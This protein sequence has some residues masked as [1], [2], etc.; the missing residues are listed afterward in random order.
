M[1]TPYDRLAYYECNCNSGYTGDY[2]QINIDEC[3]NI[4]CQNGGM[5]QDLINAFECQCQNGYNGTICEYNI[6]DCYN[7]PCGE[8]GACQ[9]RLAE[10]S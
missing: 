5:C 9:A 8:Y 2:C 6:D 10:N 4:E 3:E 1:M 7:E